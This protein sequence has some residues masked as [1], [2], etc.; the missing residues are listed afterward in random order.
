MEDEQI[1]TGTFDGPATELSDRL[2]QRTGPMTVAEQQRCNAVRPSPR[3]A[4]AHKRR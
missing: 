1:L 3:R 2:H 4:R